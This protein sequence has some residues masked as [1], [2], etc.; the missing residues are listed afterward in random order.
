[1][2]KG[3]CEESTWFKYFPVLETFFDSLSCS[4]NASPLIRKE[5]Q[6]C[7][8]HKRRRAEIR[9]YDPPNPSPS[10]HHKFQLLP[11]AELST[12][13]REISAKHWFANQ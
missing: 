5:K 9:N 8:L 2:R 10:P 1:M 3:E 11:D 13:F 4:V 12:A 6:R 7:K